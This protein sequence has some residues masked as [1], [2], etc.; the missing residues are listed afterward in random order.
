MQSLSAKV[1]TPVSGGS[2]KDALSGL[3]DRLEKVLM[4]ENAILEANQTVQ[5]KHFIESKNQILRELLVLQRS[6]EVQQIVKDQ[7]SRL[8]PV[9]QLI[10]RNYSLL[11]S[12][13]SAVNEIATALTDA[14]LKE[15][16]D[17]TYSRQI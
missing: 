17:G 14:A 12:H 10:D 8:A 1:A 15:D 3:F 11:Q 9:R 2:M 6:T 4:E 16:A 13:V 5:H 7:A